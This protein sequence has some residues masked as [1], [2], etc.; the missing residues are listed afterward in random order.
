M[1]SRWGLLC[2][3]VAALGGL[4]GCGGGAADRSVPR[5]RIDVSRALAVAAASPYRLYWV[6]P[7][8]EGLPL[9]GVT[10]DPSLASFIYGTC[11]PTGGDGGCE[12]PLEI[13]VASICDRNALVLDVRPRARFVARGATVLDYGEGTVEVAVGAS[14]VVVATRTDRARRALTALRPVVASRPTSRLAP[15]RYPRY[16]LAQLRRVS[17]VYARTRSVRAARDQLRISQSAARFELALAHDVGQERLARGSRTT[18]RLD[19]VKR[20][21]LAATL[22]AEEGARQAAR[23]SGITQAELLRR[24]AE[25]RA[26]RSGCQLEPAEADRTFEP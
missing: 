2:V 1:S 19:D 20:D 8:F 10:R 22:A 12:P 17:N 5:G 11:K 16:Y 13:Q 9:T 4:V 7:S 25:G 24:A 6:G 26:L 3:A 23:A 14:D 15:A 21:R 18:Q